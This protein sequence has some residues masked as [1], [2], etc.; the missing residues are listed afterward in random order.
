M[1][2][3]RHHLSGIFNITV[4]PFAADGAIDFP[5]L[6]E[7]I[8]RVVGLGYDGILIG[9]TYGEF[10]AMSPDERAE[11]F[12]R[13]V[14]FA[15]GAVPVV[16]CTAASD[17]RVSFKLTHLAIDLGG[18]PM[19]TAPYVSEITEDQIVDFFGSIAPIAKGRLVVYNAPGI[20]ITL[21]ARL[22]ERLAQI[23]GVAALKQ[24][25][26]SATTIDEL[27]NRVGGKIKLF[28][29][30]DLA[31][32]GPIMAGFDGLSSTNSCAFPELI[33]ATY[34][35]VESGDARSAIALHRSWYKFRELARRFGQPQ[36]V[37]AAMAHRGWG[38]GKV[39]LPL[40]PLTPTQA[41][42]VATVTDQIL[43]MTR[44][45]R[46]RAAIA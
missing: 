10:P 19:V 1:Q 33:L 44:A 16:L 31:F 14:E 41:A 37:K 8:Q 9:G 34:R 27:A 39:R 38:N 2:P 42:E 32:L 22:I 24:G 20:G 35:A 36:T 29:A 45:P 4:T 6:S 23:G 18:Y 17:T 7:E 12:R 46:Q 28:C 13:S 30:S 21:S 25:D 11:L 40:Q 26:L 3:D 5:A 15:G 43:A